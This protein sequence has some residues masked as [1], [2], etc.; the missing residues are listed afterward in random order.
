MDQYNASLLSYL[1]SVKCLSNLLILGDLNLPDI[2]W[3]TYSGITNI[4]N[5]YAEMAFD[6]NLTQLITSPTHIAGNVPGCDF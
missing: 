4:S 3:S 2:D 1:Y 6:L 5:A